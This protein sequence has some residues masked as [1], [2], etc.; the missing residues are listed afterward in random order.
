MDDETGS[1]DLDAPTPGVKPVSRALVS[2]YRGLA[3]LLLN[4]LLLLLLVNLVLGAYYW[5]GDAASVGDRPVYS[6]TFKPESY[7][8]VARDVAAAVGREFDRMGERES[9]QF[10][11]WTGFIE[12]GFRGEFVNVSEAGIRRTVSI[13]APAD[14]RQ[15][16]VV[17][18]FGGSTTFGW[19]MPDAE[20]IPSHFQAELQ[21]LVPDRRVQVVNDG[22]AYYTSAQELSLLLA[23][24]R[25][26]TPPPNVVTFLNGLNDAILTAHGRVLPPFSEISAQG[27]AKEKV[28]RQWARELT[29]RARL[30]WFEL[31]RAF[32]LLR[33]AEGVRG[34]D[35]VPGRAWGGG[36]LGPVESR[37]QGG[38]KPAELAARNYRI[39]RL[40]A[41]SAARGVG[42]RAVQ[43][44]QPAPGVGAYR[45]NVGS[46]D[47]KALEFYRRLREPGAD[48][49]GHDIYDA[50]LDLEHPYVDQHHYSDAGCLAVA[51]RMAEIVA[52]ELER[53][54]TGDAQ[55]R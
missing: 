50:V 7:T 32:P 30:D 24:L 18:M 1:N 53:S 45:A 8:R 48:P 13:P 10:H 54:P 14:A 37:L 27:W 26:D 29:W 5:I 43:F 21:R 16:L 33:L 15:D 23:E 38:S 3:L 42:A 28:E 40:L 2:L 55:H 25:R 41:D 51:R 12:S 52:A 49:L 34:A 11:P 44:L 20:T 19:G 39:N 22:H 47:P 31:T 9:Y 4:T 36:L 6:L 35:V 17:W 46:L